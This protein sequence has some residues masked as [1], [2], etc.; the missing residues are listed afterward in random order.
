VTDFLK[1]NKGMKSHKAVE[2]TIIYHFNTYTSI[3]AC[4]AKPFRTASKQTSSQALPPSTTRRP[5]TRFTTSRPTR[6]FIDRAG[7]VE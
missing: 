6:R 7:A 1:A 4:K 5:G 2:A 3:T